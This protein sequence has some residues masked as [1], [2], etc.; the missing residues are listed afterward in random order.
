[1]FQ[2]VFLYVYVVFVYVYT[3]N[4]STACKVQSNSHYIEYFNL[5]ANAVLLAHDETW[6]TCKYEKEWVFVVLR[7]T[8]CLGFLH[9]R[10][11]PL[12]ESEKSSVVTL[13]LFL[14]SIILFI[15]KNREKVKL[16]S[17]PAWWCLACEA[18]NIHPIWI[19]K[20]CTLDQNCI[21][22]PLIGQ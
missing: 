16:L 3:S 4:L 5:M 20:I 13:N 7:W 17:K 9:Q 21:R 10:W 11:D 22:C 8:W 19:L 15:F 14:T 18:L 12:N 2:L 1:M 6:W